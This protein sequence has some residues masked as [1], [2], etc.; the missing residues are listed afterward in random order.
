[1]KQN[2]LTYNAYAQ[3]GFLITKGP[4]AKLSINLEWDREPILTTYIVLIDNIRNS[5]SSV[6]E[7]D[8]ESEISSRFIIC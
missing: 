2:L 4:N 3:N 6:L 8:K 1:M 7:I 5:R